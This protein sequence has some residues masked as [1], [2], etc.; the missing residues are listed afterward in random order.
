MSRR[1]SLGLALVVSVIAGAGACADRTDQEVVVNAAG[2]HRLEIPVLTAHDLDLLFVIDNSPA[3]A[4][5]RAK[6]LESYRRFIQVLEA[7][8]GGLPNVHIGVVT[9]DVGTRGAYDPGPGPSIGTGDGSC[10]ADGDR[11]ALRRA[12]SV[13]GNF[14][15]DI[16]RPDGTRERNYTGSLADAFVQLADVGAAGCTYARPLEAMRR[17][18]VGNPANVGFLRRDAPLAVVLLTNG[19]D[20]SFGSASFVG[21]D[22][23]RSRCTRDAD[24]LVPVD[25]YV[26]ALRSIKSDPDRIVVLGGFAPPDQPAC[27][28]T[29]PAA[30]LAAFLGGFGS[31][32]RTVSICE[33]EL[34]DLVEPATYFIR[35]LAGPPC[36]GEPVLDVDPVTEGLQP[37]CASWY[38]YQDHGETVEEIIPACRGDEPGPCWRLYR[39]PQYCPF[40]AETV[41]FRHRLGFDASTRAVAILECVTR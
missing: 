1:F 28:D 33:P 18:L 20:C 10:T 4:P 13:D 6:L 38:R 7:A 11:G 21:D 36:L 30:R 9:T 26:A 14:L 22:L 40:D 31:H 32:G 41:E 19:D 27:A 37:D 8:R 15:S 3:M 5:Q 16:V 12:P 25:E 29:Q 24:A 2:V 39:D 34:G 35:T 17:A 23:D